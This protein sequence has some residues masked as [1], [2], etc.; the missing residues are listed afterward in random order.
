MLLI[1]DLYWQEFCKLRDSKQAHVCKVSSVNVAR[2]DAANLGCLL[3]QFPNLDEPLR[4]PL[5]SDETVNSLVAGSEEILDVCGA[6]YFKFGDHRSC[7]VGLRLLAGAKKVLES[8]DGLE[9]GS[10]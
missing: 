6:L 10:L 4:T 3:Q 5:S 1:L 7:A 8:V 2:C 9:L